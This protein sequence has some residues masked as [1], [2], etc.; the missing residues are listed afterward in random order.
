MAE[1]CD[2]SNKG[3]SS[4]RQEKD[5]KNVLK[6][7][8]AVMPIQ[9]K[10]DGVKSFI[11]IT[12]LPVP[13]TTFQ[14]MFL[15]PDSG[16]RLHCVYDLKNTAFEPQ[17]G[18]NVDWEDGTSSTVRDPNLQMTFIVAETNPIFN[19]NV[20]DLDC[21]KPDTFLYLADGSMV[22]YADR[23]T[24]SVDKKVYPLPVQKWTTVVTPI[25]SDTGVPQVAVTID[26]PNS[27][28]YKNWVV[29]APDE[30][31]FDISENYEA[32]GALLVQGTTATTATSL[33]VKATL[34]GFGI[35]GNSSLINGLTIA[36]FLIDNNGTPVTILTATA[37]V[38]GYVLTFA[39][40]TSGDTLITN[41]APASGYVSDKGTTLVP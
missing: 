15:E 25:T 17:D 36:D 35:L 31:D 14:A 3:V 29:I 20:K 23:N 37:S 19:G 38:T 41:L 22:G 27:M 16:K 5:C 7:V 30:H 21:K 10:D 32:K 24:I 34:Y 28:S 18:V 12:T 8:V 40:Q 33:E 1:L 26:F 2:C 39:S 6:K 4:L 11:D 13:A 9:R